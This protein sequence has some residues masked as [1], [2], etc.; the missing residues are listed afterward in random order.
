MFYVNN[1]KLSSDPHLST[2]TDGSLKD[3]DST[4]TPPRQLFKSFKVLEA[5]ISKIEDLEGRLKDAELRLDVIDFYGPN[6]PSDDEG[7]YD[8]DL[9]NDRS[10]D[11]EA[12][13]EKLRPE[14]VDRMLDVVHW[15]VKA[16]TGKF[17]PP[18][19]LAMVH[20]YLSLEDD[21]DDFGDCDSTDS[22]IYNGKGRFGTEDEDESDGS[23]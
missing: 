5:S 17:L 6:P 16:E 4:T 13:L 7:E 12:Q 18:E 8:E 19:I 11:L 15:A 20:G 23:E 2:S 21:E 3:D 1:P 10:A 22:E 14:H 9:W